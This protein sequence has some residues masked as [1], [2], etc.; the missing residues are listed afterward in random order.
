MAWGSLDN[1][2]S[3]E[4]SLN[5]MN[6]TDAT[7]NGWKVRQF[8]LATQSEF[9]AVEDRLRIQFGF[10]WASGDPDLGSIAPTGQGLQPQLTA[11]RTYSE[12]Q[13]HPDYRID[14]IL[15]RNILTRVQGAYYFRP[16][17][18]YDFTR[19]KNGQKL[20]GGAAV[21]WSRASQFIQAPGHQR[22][23]G[24]EL[25]GKI[26]FQSRDGTLNDNY[27]KM[28]GFYTSLEYGVLFPLAGLGYLP[29]QQTAYNMQTGGRLLMAAWSAG[30]A[31]SERENPRRRRPRV[32]GSASVRARK[33]APP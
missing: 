2:S 12:F 30:H 8:G 20:G 18:E 9:R 5:Y 27:E 26:Y 11:D 16:S 19:D 4:G 10:G 25:N 13:F 6:P 23:L 21:I 7:N 31:P 1:T 29:L 24:V 28:G 22:D 17:V 33:E 32:E 15:F 14:L 3:T